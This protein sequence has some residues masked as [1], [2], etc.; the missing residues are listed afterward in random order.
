MR[1]LVCQS[2]SAPT[3]Q[4]PPYAGGCR[5]L[6]EIVALGLQGAQFSITAEADP[7]LTGPRSAA[8]ER[9]AAQLNGAAPASAQPG[10]ADSGVHS[11]MLQ[12][13]C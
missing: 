2:C 10:G 3:V 7:A 5:R 11:C 13:L 6:N 4:A 8:E 1:N 9:L 12:A